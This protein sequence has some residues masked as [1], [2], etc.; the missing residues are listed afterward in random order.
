[1]LKTQKSQVF[2]VFLPVIFK[3]SHFFDFSFLTF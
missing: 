1:M 2:F 3:K